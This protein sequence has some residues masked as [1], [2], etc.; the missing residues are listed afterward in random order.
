MIWLE[1]ISPGEAT[2]S[3]HQAGA[4]NFGGITTEA[5]MA[6]LVDALKKIGLFTY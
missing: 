2:P 3:V 6:S 5:S 1:E 4:W